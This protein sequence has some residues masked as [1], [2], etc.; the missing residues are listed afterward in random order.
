MKFQ[1]AWK[2]VAGIQE[3]PDST[4]DDGDATYIDHARRLLT[5]VYYRFVAIFLLFAVPRNELRK[6]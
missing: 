5:Q 1:E 3:G 6:C 4:P 2:R